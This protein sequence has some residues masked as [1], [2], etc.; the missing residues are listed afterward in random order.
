MTSGTNAVLSETTLK[1]ADAKTLKYQQW[2]RSPPPI[3]RGGWSLT[4]I[5]L[6]QQAVKGGQVLD[7]ELAKDPLV[8][9]DA[10]Q[11]R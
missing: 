4:Y 8:R 3:K 11:S 5:V 6:L 2:S 10:Q 9:L 7:D 1:T